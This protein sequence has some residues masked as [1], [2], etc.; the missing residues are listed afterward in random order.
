VDVFICHAGEQKKDFVDTLRTLLKDVHKLSVFLDEHNL[1]VGDHARDKMRDSLETASV[2]KQVEEVLPCMVSQQ[3]HLFHIASQ[4][5]DISSVSC[6]AV[7][8]LSPEFIR[9]KAPMQEL[10]RTL[11]KQKQPGGPKQQQVCPIYHTLSIEECC[12]SDFR[13][14]YDIQPWESFNLPEPKPD[15]ATLDG[16]ARDIGE[17]C[18]IT[19][20]RQDQVGLI[21][22]TFDRIH[23]CLELYRKDLLLSQIFLVRSVLFS[24]SCH[25]LYRSVLE[26]V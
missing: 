8:V 5:H 16:Y 2:G 25:I 18:K 1:L 19:G 4:G 14:Q 7:L 13:Q 17:L 22:S 10:R 21:T 24:L 11:E 26:V 3:T 6:A 12:R 20:L 15:A 9:K 23:K